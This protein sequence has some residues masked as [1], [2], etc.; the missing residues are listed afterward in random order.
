[1]QKLSQ[2]TF[3]LEQFV[4]VLAAVCAAFPAYQWWAEAD[5][6][7][8][9]RTASRFKIIRDCDSISSFYTST[10]ERSVNSAWRTHHADFGLERNKIHDFLAFLN[11]DYMDGRLSWQN[12]FS[13]CGLSILKTDASFDQIIEVIQA[14]GGRNIVSDFAKHVQQG[15]AADP[16]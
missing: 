11:N 10:I 12:L 7:A 15:Q 6:R 13:K 5:D 1:M 14:D 9:E 16:G 3:A 2:L 8:F 4:V